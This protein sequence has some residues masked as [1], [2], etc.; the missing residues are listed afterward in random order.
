MV[1][2]VLNNLL[3]TY[4]SEKQDRIVLVCESEKGECMLPQDLK[5]LCCQMEDCCARGPV[6]SAHVN[7]S[8][9]IGVDKDHDPSV[10]TPELSNFNLSQIEQAAELCEG[11]SS[12]LIKPPAVS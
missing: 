3:F 7:F 4:A 8:V 9:I 2:F 6:Q 5:D 12:S 10:Q 11:H 1:C